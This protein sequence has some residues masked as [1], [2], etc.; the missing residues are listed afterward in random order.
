MAFCCTLHFQSL[1]F[2]LYYTV[3]LNLNSVT[4]KDGVDQCLDIHPRRTLPV[5]AMFEESTPPPLPTKSLLLHCVSL[6]VIP[7]TFFCKSII[8]FYFW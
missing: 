7:E 8:P 1:V 4:P 2:T 3:P 6:C 5:G